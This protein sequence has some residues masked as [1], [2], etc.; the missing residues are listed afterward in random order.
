MEQKVLFST[1]NQTHKRKFLLFTTQL[2]K[3]FYHWIVLES[4]SIHQQKSF[5]HYC[6]T[7]YS[8]KSQYINLIG[9]NRCPKFWK[10]LSNQHR[11]CFFILQPVLINNQSMSTKSKF[12]SCANFIQYTK[13]YQKNFWTKQT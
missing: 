4:S 9:Q 11:F 13:K 6:F 8:T 7:I 1:V 2:P 5:N 12:L 3:S 10:F